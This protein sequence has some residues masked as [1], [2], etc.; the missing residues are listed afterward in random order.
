MINLTDLKHPTQQRIIESV[1]SGGSEWTRR[2]SSVLLKIDAIKLHTFNK[3]YEIPEHDNDYAERLR[4][5][6][7][8]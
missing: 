4:Q 2:V 1:K 3:I 7:I 5:L 6:H 8:N